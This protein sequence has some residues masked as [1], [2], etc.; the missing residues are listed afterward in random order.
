[1]TEQTPPSDLPDILDEFRNLWRAELYATSTSDSTA[2]LALYEQATENENAGLLSKALSDYRKAI[3][4]DPN[5]EDKFRIWVMERNRMQQEAATPAHV[6]PVR[7][8][9]L[10]TSAFNIFALPEEI[11]LKCFQF[12][13]SFDLSF[14][15][16]LSLVSKRVHEMI[17]V[18]SLYKFIAI[19]LHA[20]T[21]TGLYEY[22][23]STL[24]WK[25]TLIE[26]PR[27]RFNGLYI[28]KVHYYRTGYSDDWN[29]PLHLVSYFRYLRVF[30]DDRIIFLTSSLE[31]SEVVKHF[32]DIASIRDR[33]GQETGLM[34]GLYTF[35]DNLIHCRMIDDKRPALSFSMGFIVRNS[36]LKKHWKVLNQVIPVGLGAL[37]HLESGEK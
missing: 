37:Y 14:I 27:L 21:S 2:A 5:V 4:L 6:E 12:A 18:Q 36:R 20:G 35:N 28:S 16:T 10:S 19:K 9:T 23:N 7:L 31:P 17:H 1:M 33:I 26:K 13:I 11:T 32:T 15:I 8:P 24:D 34:T 25:Q 30:R 29:Q 22:Y 3:R